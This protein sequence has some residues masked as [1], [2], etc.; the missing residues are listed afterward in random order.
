MTIQYPDT[1]YYIK[2]FG[3]AEMDKAYKVEEE[4]TYYDGHLDTS[5]K[6]YYDIYGNKFFDPITFKYR[7]DGLM[8]SIDGK[9]RYIF[10]YG[11]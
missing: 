6:R 10:S 11:K 2:N 7:Y 9:F 8:E 1:A 5:V 4:F 3:L